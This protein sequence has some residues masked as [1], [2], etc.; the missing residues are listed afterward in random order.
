MKTEH[1]YLTLSGLKKTQKFYQ[2][3]CDRRDN[4]NKKKRSGISS[5]LEN[6]ADDSDLDV[7][8]EKEILRGQIAEY[9]F[10]LQHYRLIAS[11]RGDKK[12]KV[13]LGATILVEMNQHVRRLH[14]V[15]SPEADPDQ[16]K[17]S[18]LSPVAKALMG[19][20]VGEEVR[21]KVIP[22]EIMKIKKIYYN[23][24]DL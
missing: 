10:I 20:I 1:I 22:P 3:L 13:G 7:V 19:R 18:Y 5:F 17:I 9:E 16:G 15:D 8:T 12:D 6:E 11:P 14:I 2:Q 24:I 21:V 4:Q 23:Q